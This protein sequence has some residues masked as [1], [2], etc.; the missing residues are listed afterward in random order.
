MW[1]VQRETFKL[2]NKSDLNLHILHIKT[3]LLATNRVHFRAWEESESEIGGCGGVVIG[4]GPKW[5][6]LCFTFPQLSHWIVGL[7]AAATVRSL[8]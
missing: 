4:I 1:F 8:G 2:S 3:G 5:A 6:Q 7:R